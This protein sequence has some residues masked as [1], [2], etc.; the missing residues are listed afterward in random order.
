MGIQ[1]G[2]NGRTTG[3]SQIETSDPFTSASTLTFMGFA[4][5]FRILLSS[6]SRVTQIVGGL[7]RLGGPHENFPVVG[8]DDQ[9]FA[10]AG[11]V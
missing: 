8:C 6:H 9:M 5:V 1:Q 3:E 7:H 2:C 4:G 10:I 11:P